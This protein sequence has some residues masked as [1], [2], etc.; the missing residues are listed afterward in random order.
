MSVSALRIH[1]SE[2]TKAILDD[3]GHF[4]TE[5]RGEVEMKVRGLWIAHVKCTML[6]ECLL[7]S[8]SPRLIR[9]LLIILNTQG[10]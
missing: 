6:V 3:F 2:Q 9:R 8:L 7:S 5:L 4:D 1:M 10:S